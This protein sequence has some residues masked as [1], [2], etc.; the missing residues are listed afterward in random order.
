MKIVCESCG[1]KYS[2]ADDRVAGKVFKIRCKR[3]SEVIVVRG[4]Q[5]AGGGAAAAAP[6]VDD[7]NAIWNVVVDGE[8]VSVRLMQADGQWRTWHGYVVRAAQL[9]KMGSLWSRISAARART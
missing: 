2:I 5:D 7:Q 1:A 3:C 9:G 6:A 4:D 8:Q